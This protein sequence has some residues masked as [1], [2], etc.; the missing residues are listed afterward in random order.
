MT[1]PRAAVS[2]L[3]ALALAACGPVATPGVVAP[4]VTPG[5]QVTATPLP[6]R[7]VFPPG[8]VFEYLAQ[9]GDTLPAV[10]A[11]FNTTVEEIRAENPELPDPVTTMPAGFLIRVPSYYSPLTSSPFHILPDSQAVNGPGAVDFDMRVEVESR[12]GYL[13]NITDYA[14]RQQRPG[15]DVVDVVARNYS[16][17]PRVL[18]TLLEY[19]TH[20][21]SDPFPDPID[22][23]Y[24]LGHVDPRSRG[25]YR[26]L[27]WAAEL[28]NDAFYGWRGEAPLEL[29]LADGKV[30][31]PDPWQNAGTVGV[32]GVMAGL[33]GQEDFNRAVGPDGFAATWRSLWGDPY[34]AVQVTIPPSLQQPALALPFP[35]NRV[36]D[37]TGGPHPS[38]GN[39]RPFGAL[40]F[41]PPAVVGGCAATNEWFTA[42]AEGVIVR[43]GDAAVVLDL[44]GDGDERTGWVI[45]FYHVATEG[46]IAA[47]TVVTRGQNLGHPS[48]EGGLATGTHFHMARRYN[49]EWIAAAGVIPF[50]LD[51]WVAAGGETAYQGT[52]TRGSMTITACTC[53]T[54]SNRILYELP[55]EPE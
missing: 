36:W 13:N 43:S 2:A 34:Q 16:I 42:P 21:L 8:Q 48:C 25:L 17:H 47:G 15:W 22:R 37:Y 14:Q 5:E 30:A 4:T 46:R 45:L 51:G 54:A 1:A 49:G 31:R 38:W 12:P 26:Q 24:P 55:S 52:L 27:I 23:A 7:T 11:H 29:E 28:F 41:A 53:T 18:L 39:G 9:P 19:R 40:D 33:F 44:D 50:D 20:A 35:P 3:L 32:Q 6:V 10:A